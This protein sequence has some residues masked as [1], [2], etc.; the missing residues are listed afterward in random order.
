MAVMIVIRILADSVFQVK[1]FKH[2]VQSLVYSPYT[3]GRSRM[4]LVMTADLNR[5][6]IEKQHFSK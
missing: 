5:S 2:T 4:D 6:S 1:I 3:R